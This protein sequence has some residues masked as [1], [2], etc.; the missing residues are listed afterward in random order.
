MTSEHEDFQ[1][2]DD[3]HHAP[4]L[5]MNRTE[6]RLVND[7]K[8][9]E[10]IRQKLNSRSPLREN[11]RH[12][13][14]IPTFWTWLGLTFNFSNSFLHFAPAFLDLMYLGL[15]KWI[16]SL[17]PSASKINWVRKCCSPK[18]PSFPSTKKR[19]PSICPSKSIPTRPH[20]HPRLHKSLQLK[21]TNFYQW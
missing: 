16:G 12:I 3:S 8:S 4:R 1:S 21:T 14:R 7:V 6:S 19:Q 11:E 15:I 9:E 18:A 20:R 10:E 13:N 5:R 2:R 17:L